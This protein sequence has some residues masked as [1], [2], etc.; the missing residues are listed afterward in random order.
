MHPNKFTKSI[1]I[2]P[3]HTSSGTKTPYHMAVWYGVCTQMPAVETFL[4]LDKIKLE[5]SYKIEIKI[6]C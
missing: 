3:Y 2:P 6:T 4:S 5:Q 1:H